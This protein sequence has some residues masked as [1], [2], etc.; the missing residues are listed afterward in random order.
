MRGKNH[1]KSWSNLL[2]FLWAGMNRNVQEA[3]ETKYI[4]IATSISS[5]VMPQPQLQG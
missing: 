3:M 1:Q 2:L 5:I 4:I